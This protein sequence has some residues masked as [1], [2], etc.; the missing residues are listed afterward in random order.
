MRR[1]TVVL[2]VVMGLGLG[3]LSAIPAPAQTRVVVP[4]IVR[5]PSLGAAASG[6]PSVQVTTRTVS[7]QPGVTQTQ[8]TVRNTTGVRGYSGPAS[9]SQPGVS[10][11]IV[12]DT[13]GFRGYSGH[14]PAPQP[15]VTRVIIRDTTGFSGY[16]SGHAMAPQPGVTH[17][18]VRDTTGTAGFLSSPAP[19]SRRPAGRYPGTPEPPAVDGGATVL[20][21]FPV[22]LRPGFGGAS[23]SLVITSDAPIDAPIVFLAD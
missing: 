4:I 23:R 7:P 9:P 14:T 3:G 19:A 15:G 22:T 6:R 18:T 11:V 12:R 2:S 13:T 8:V 10:Q 17:V 21:P 16:S 5:S 1:E 20:V